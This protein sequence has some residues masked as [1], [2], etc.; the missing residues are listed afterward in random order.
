M[1]VVA[2][3]GLAACDGGNETVSELAVVEVR[4]AMNGDPAAF[5]TYFA[6]I[7]GQKVKWSGRV[8]ESVRQF[9]DDYIEEGVLLV[10]LD[11]EGQSTEATDA[12]FEISP[13]QIDSF[14]PDQPVTFIAVI[15][16]FEPSPDGPILKLE[17]KEIQ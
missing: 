9:G 12:R 17:L 1:G 10:D 15:R 11:P 8:V 2:G 4:Q 3:L 5:E 7:K 6:S 16:E 13:S 14:K